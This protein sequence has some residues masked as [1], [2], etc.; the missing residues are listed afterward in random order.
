MR[1][2]QQA[3]LAAAFGVLLGT[4]AL[5]ACSS[6]QVREARPQ[7]A[8]VAATGP[9]ANTQEFAVPPAPALRLISQSEYTHSIEQ[10]FGSDVS[11]KIRFAPVNRTDGLLSVGRS[12][13]VLTGGALDPLDSAARSVAAQVVDP[14]HRSFLIPCE[15]KNV[16]ARDDRC[17]RTYLASVGRLIF[18]RPLTSQELAQVVHTAGG[19][20]GDFYTGLRYALSGMLISP[21]FL[22]IRENVEPD[23]D[24]HGAWRLDAYSKAAR[25]STV[26]WNSS[27]DDELLRAAEHGEL[28]TA[29]GLT[30]QIDRMIGSPLYRQG[31]RAFFT[32]FFVLESFDTLSKD[33]IIY[34]AFTLKAV[35]EAR[36]QILRTV[37]NH[38]VDRDGDYR[39]L[40]T[41][42][43][44]FL[45]SDLA[46]LYRIQVNVGAQGWVPYEFSDN[47]PRA[48]LLTQIG[49][50]SQYA[51][52][53]RSSSTRR[54]RAIREVLLC[55]KV[56]DPPPNVDFSII[57]DP[58]AHFHTA[59]ERLAAHQQN[60]VCAGCHALTDPIGL[61]LEN[62]DGA[63]EYRSTE[64]DAP[65]DASGRLDGSQFRDG[66]GLGE[67]VRNSP[68]LKSCVVN[69]LYAYS[70]G[71]KVVPDEK[72]LLKY[73]ESVLDQRG[74]RFDTMLRL[75]ILDK[76]FFAVSAPDSTDLPT[77][78]VAS[79]QL[80][81][82][83]SSH[84]VQ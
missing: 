24:K 72:P 76:S 12:S 31:V 71:R 34:P 18:R 39:D 82:K 78:T 68:A 10:I 35:D 53:G 60:P 30:R 23:P 45:S 52:P 50:L 17:A 22:F 43:Q 55:Q 27:P 32:D 16:K 37:V 44:T 13:A 42:R 9:P 81:T 2:M 70:V 29:V 33:P 59:R 47:D 25:L 6:G 21:E 54:G 79:N 46:V 77:H 75:M 51:H 73:Y 66:I 14:A 80:P 62:F 36:E 58:K 3:I 67:A 74:Y 83:G 28:N 8:P 61:A 20:D 15:P 4:V 41:T 69:R 40:F 5:V 19:A 48:G 65:I 57:E 7:G 49:F 1:S 64:N 38:L 63:G 56:P 26:L 11:V 84:A